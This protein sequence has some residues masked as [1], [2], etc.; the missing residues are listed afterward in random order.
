M[1]EG[2]SKPRTAGGP[3]E[4][5][6]R[7]GRPRRRRNAIAVFAGAAFSARPRRGTSRP[8]SRYAPAWRASCP[9]PRRTPPPNRCDPSGPGRDACRRTGRV[10]RGASAERPPTPRS[11]AARCPRCSASCSWGGSSS[12]CSTS[13]SRSSRPPGPPSAGCWAGA[14]REQCRPSSGGSSTAGARRSTPSAPRW[15]S[16]PS[17]GSPSAWPCARRASAGSTATSSP[18]SR[19][20]SWC[21]RWPSPCAGSAPPCR[22]CSRTPSTRR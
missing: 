2:S 7:R 18:A 16:S 3:D 21:R 8:G 5:R 13:T 22:P 17:R 20:C 9:T 4:G 19:C 14:S 1:A 15:S 6:G 10:A 11:A 12:G